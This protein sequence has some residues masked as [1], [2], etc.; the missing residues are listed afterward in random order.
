M[1]PRPL[2]STLLIGL[3]LSVAPSALADGWVH[4]GD[5]VRVKS[6]GF[7]SVNVYSIGHDIN[8]KPEKSKQAVIDAAMDKK[9]TLTMLREVPQEKIRNAL[10][11]AFKMNGYGGDGRTGQF[12]AVLN[13]KGPDLA[14]G[15][16]ISINYNAGSKTTSI[17]VDG[18]GKASIA[19]EDFMKG[20][21]KIWFGKIDQPAL[22]DQLLAKL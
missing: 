18:G 3:A 17:A 7:I 8:G 12:I 11:D 22:G 1:N 14:K 16:H 2:L 21:W 15:A 19:G 13:D 5:G 9:F 10:S 4:T 20:V 6:I